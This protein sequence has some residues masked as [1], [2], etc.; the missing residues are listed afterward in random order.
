[1]KSLRFSEARAVHFL[2]EH[3]INKSGNEGINCVFNF[4][5]YAES[6]GWLNVDKIQKDLRPSRVIKIIVWIN[7]QAIK[8]ATC[9]KKKKK[10]Q[11]TS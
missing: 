1:M 7:K 8:E 2:F 6:H 3:Y 5:N 10:K 4:L 11:K 9:Q